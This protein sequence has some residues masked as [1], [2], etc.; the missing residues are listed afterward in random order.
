MVTV[1]VAALMVLMLGLGTLITHE[2][3]KKQLLTTDVL[4]SDVVKEDHIFTRQ[5]EARLTVQRTYCGKR[6]PAWTKQN[7]CKWFEE[8]MRCVFQICLVKE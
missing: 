1:P 2:A 4:L 6:K 7:I 3:V 5:G 8:C